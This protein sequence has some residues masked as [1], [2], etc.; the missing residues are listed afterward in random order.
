M[1]KRLLRVA[2]AA[3]LAS[4]SGGAYL[5]AQAA[6]GTPFN[7]SP[8][9]LP[10]T[11]Q[12]E[13]FDKGGEGVG[14]HE[15]TSGN[16]GGAYRTSESVDIIASTDSQGG[17]FVVNN[18]GT[19]EWLAY[20]VNVAT[21]GNYDFA[22]RASNNYG[23]GTPAFHIEVDGANVTG[24]VPVPKTGGWNTFQDVV[25][26]GIPLTAGTHV[27]KLV[28]DG[29]YFNVNSLKVTAS[30][31]SG[32]TSGTSG[33]ATGYTGTPYTGTPIAVPV[34]FQAPNFD[35][36]GEGVAYHDLS[37]GNLGKL[38]RTSESVD[39]YSSTDTASGVYQIANFQSGEWMNYTINVPKTGNYDLSLRAANNY[40][41]GAFHME[42]DGKDVT[43]SISVPKT[44]S[45][46]TY[47][48]FG[49]QGVP[50]T[51]GKHVLKVV[52]DTQYFNVSA[53][54][55]LA[56]GTTTGGTTGGTTGD[57]TGGTTTGST[58]GT[59]TG[60]TSGSTIAKPANMLF[61][62]GFE[63]IALGTPNSCYS[64]GCFQDI[65]GTDPST[66]FSWP[67]KIAGG[68]GR[69]QLLTNSSTTPT[70]S[71]VNNWMYNQFQKVTGRTGAQTTAL[72]S[73][74]LQSGCCGT[75]AQ[76]GGSTQ[77]PYL[78]NPGQ[79]PGDMYISFWRKLQP[80]WT[81][82]L[83]AGDPW[84]V[85][86]EWKTAGDYRIS[87]NLVGWG[88]KAPFWQLRADNNANGGLPMQEF[89]RTYNTAVPVPAADAWWKF[90]VFWHRSSGND[91]RVWMAVNGKVLVDKYGPNIGVNNKPINRIFLSQL[92][93]GSPYPIYQWTDDVQVWS[94][95]PTAKPGDPWYDAVY[96]PH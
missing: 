87:A 57:T 48:W 84:R 67:P 88:G 13:N 15:L 21:S 58:G 90:E 26:Q 40:G 30:A 16:S 7:G 43:G 63:G 47:K 24:S 91:G 19:G 22:V 95:F 4:L 23:S 5:A 17:G 82:K 70:S 65:N 31:T 74:I 92:Y 41:T 61:W 60:S 72:Y 96:A 51:A 1:Q 42:V 2:I 77:L 94:T 59:P 36:G 81:Q 10:G 69:F 3:A 32:T 46:T 49:K 6:S 78:I 14:Y 85:V 9:A 12:A 71:T 89:W 79:E 62:S 29:Q 55:V 50:L 68:S 54:S 80:D 37:S 52:A 73:H 33:S 11:L 27:V 64:N 39:I 83:A 93:A 53:L 66:G 86:F 28:A 38:Y 34:M 20:T 45:W 76:G 18:F 75:S 35:K 8:A 44:G 56:S 25:K